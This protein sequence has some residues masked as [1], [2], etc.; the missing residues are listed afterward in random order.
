MQLTQCQ[1]DLFYQNLKVAP[2][3]STDFI[4]SGYTKYNLSTM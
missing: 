2:F 3:N 4:D 1:A